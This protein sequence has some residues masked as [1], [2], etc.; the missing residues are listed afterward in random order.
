MEQTEETMLVGKHRG[1]LMEFWINYRKNKLSVIGGI[2]V[3]IFVLFALF[4]PILAR[5]SMR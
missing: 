1:I 2:I 4:A 3:L 5:G